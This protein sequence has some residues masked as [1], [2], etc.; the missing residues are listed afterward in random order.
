M[1]PGRSSVRRNQGQRSKPGLRLLAFFR[2]LIDR[3][4][5][6]AQRSGQGN[7]NDRRSRTEPLPQDKRHPRREGSKSKRSVARLGLFCCV[8]LLCIWSSWR[9]IADTAAHNLAVSAPETAL[10]W[11]ANDSIALNELAQRELLDPA[12]DLDAGQNWARRA[13]YARPVD[14]RALFLLGLIATRKGDSQRT[15]VLMTNAGAR[16]WRNP[17]AQFWLFGRKIQQHEYA[18]ALT[19]ADAALRV[20]PEVQKLI[21]PTL[22][23]FIKAAPAFPVLVDFLATVPPWRTAFLGDLSSTLSDQAQLDKLYASLGKSSHPPTKDELR[24]YLA[25]LIQGKHFQD[26]YRIWFDSLSASERVNQSRPY[27]ADFALPA[28]SLPFNWTL[29]PVPGADIQ[30]VA[31]SESKDRAL[32]IQFSGARVQ[33]AN[34]RQMLVLPPGSYRL[35][36]SVKSD[37]LHTS[38]GL[39]WHIFCAASPN[40]NLGHTQ[41]ISGT[42]SWRTFTASF[43]VPASGCEAQWLQLELPA[44]IASEG[45]IEGQVWYRSL[46]ITPA[47]EGSPGG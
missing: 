40:I 31:L 44:R 3:A 26:A 9:I 18:Q 38:R 19:H 12:G 34:V 22:A 1:R 41:P 37:E 32:R 29:V 36:G 43:E 25:R 23:A 4:P 8:V 39:W 21:Y 17:G 30:V 2:A 42:V 24:P 5:D 47:S 14:D 7:K 10:R 35:T 16:T 27:N 33:F 13:L 6:R 20:D 15:D 28:D 11:R 45:Q 46:R